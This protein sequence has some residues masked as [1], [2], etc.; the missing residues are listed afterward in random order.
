[1][2][3]ND[4]Y[5]QIS[6]DYGATFDPRV[7]LTMNVD[8]EEGY[9][10][11]SDASA[12]IDSDNNLHIG[13]GGR[14]WPADANMGGQVG[15]LR[16]RM[17]HWGENLGLGGFDGNGDAIIRTAVDLA[18]D[19]TVCNGGIWN[20]NGA[21]MSVS[22]C[23]GK[24]YFLWTQFNDIPNGVEDDCHDRAFGSNSDYS[25]SA[26]G[27]LYVAVSDNGGMNWDY[28]RNL[29][30]TRTPHCDSI[31]GPVGRCQSEM[32]SSMARF[33]TNH[34]VGSN[35]VIVDPSGGYTGDYF[36]DVQYID[37]P[38]PGAIVYDEG[39]WQQ[40]S[41][42]WFRMP[43][44]E[45]VPTP[46]WAPS[47]QEIDYPEYTKHGTQYDKS[48]TIENDG[49][50][51]TNFTMTLNEDAGPHSGWLSVSASLSAGTIGFGEDNTVSG[52]VTINAG[53]TINLP[54]TLVN[55]R[56]NMTATGN[57]VGSPYVFPI[58]F[59]IVD[60]V[61]PPMFDT[62]ST[63]CFSLVV[64]NLG[65]W[66]NQGAGHVNLDFFDYGDCD[67]SEGEQDTI[68]GDATVYVN[69]ASP[70]ICWPDGDSVICNWSIYGNGPSSENSFI[71][72]G[73][74]ASVPF[75]VGVCCDSP[76]E[77][78]FVEDTYFSQFVTRDTGILIEKWWVH[79]DQSADQG[80]N[81]I[82]QIL[83]I[84][85]IDGQTHIGLNIG[86]AIDWDI[87]A[88]TAMRNR[89]GFDA[90]LK[91][92]Y[93]QGSEYD[94]D[95][96]E[97]MDNSDRYGGIE[98]LGIREDDD[99]TVT[100]SSYPYGAWSGSNSLWVHPGGGFDPEEL[101]SLMTAREG[102]VLSDSLDADLY[103]M[104]TFK[105]GYTLTPTKTL[106]VYKCL[107]TSR[108]GYAAFIASAQECHDWYYEYFVSGLIG[109]CC[110]PPLRGNVDYD[111]AD[112]IDISDLV[113]LVDF[114]FAGGQEPPCFEE[115]DINGDGV[116]DISDLVWFVDF[117]FSFG[118]PPAPCP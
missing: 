90:G 107:I 109:P 108:L 23:D 80:S 52:T 9:R 39:T 44:V 40:S 104:M 81:W 95:P 75:F 49:N 115:A 24:L 22:E 65:N 84:T 59:F 30:N 89:S 116:I 56:G 93:Q 12:L 53:G 70:V 88:D 74:I 6:H 110:I 13:W 10:P 15:L 4:I 98:L 79:P 77:S 78:L 85:V 1:D 16:G 87:P 8:G 26:N 18:W 118:A 67:N 101:D 2:M 60:T 72:V 63:G 32:W 25:G 43:C 58:N 20:L 61:V 62:I 112:A 76:T 27:E 111:G 17:F 94:E 66:G 45:P 91:L 19:Q 102:Y 33:G 73:H 106:W 86:E 48:L 47:W 37:D 5:Y 103:S 71:P 117:M 50:T 99:G 21:K 31:D 3:D 96:E 7:N 11:F 113:Y 34:A 105:S 54:G 29:T 46:G 28:P 92:V 114:M 100:E 69:D 82:I 51:T 36:L 83:R 68:P 57:L 97:C 42:R 41:V 64:S 38:D 55:L 35:V 14:Y